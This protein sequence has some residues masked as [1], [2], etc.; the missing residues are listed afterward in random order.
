M[1]REEKL[2]TMTMGCLVEVANR[3]GIKIDK[4]GAKAK[5]V[6]K[7]LDAEAKLNDNNCGDG[8]P[9]AVVGKEIAADAKKKADE[10]K[11]LNDSAKTTTEIINKAEAKIDADEKKAKKPAK[12]AVKT[13]KLDKTDVINVIISAG[14]DCTDA[15]KRDIK[16]GSKLATVYVGSKTC[17]LYFNSEPVKD[18]LENDGF[19]VAT[20]KEKFDFY[21][22]LDIDTLRTV[23]ALL[24]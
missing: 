14:L 1:T 11:K 17:T 20:S 9:L 16:I 4:K 7:I 5:A 23:L 24:G 19:D 13:V 12:K 10:I 15:P 22:K 6:A 18:A 2:Y 21:C 8:T 3:L